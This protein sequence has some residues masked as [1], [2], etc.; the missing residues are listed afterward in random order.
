MNILRPNP[1]K[2]WI[3]YAV[4]VGALALFLTTHYLS[5]HHAAKLSDEYA[6]VINKSSKQRMLS[7][8]IALFADSLNQDNF[9][10]DVRDGLESSVVEF[11]TSHAAL[12]S[13][14]SE[15][16]PLSPALHALYFGSGDGNGLDFDVRTYI[17]SARKQ[18][19]SDT[20]NDAINTELQIA[21]RGPL[22]EKLDR[23]V[24]LYEQEAVEAISGIRETARIGFLLSI[25]VLALEA[26]L[27]FWPAHRSIVGSLSELRR[28]NTLLE[29]MVERAKV[30]MQE[31]RVTRAA[32][33]AKSDFLAHMSHEFR[34][35]L[36]AISG[37]AE[38]MT[39]IGVRNLPPEKID[40]YLNDIHASSLHLR[41]MVSDVLDI[42]RI[43]SQQ[44][45]V[46][47]EHHQVSELLD[48]ALSITRHGATQRGV[49]LQIKCD[50]LPTVLCDRRSMAKCLVNILHNAI[51]Y[52]PKGSAIWITVEKN[53]DETII[54]VE[55][56]GKGFP[57]EILDNIGQPFLRSSD[58][59]VS[60][61]E[62]AGL[63]L[64]ITK[65]LM[66][67]QNGSLEIRNLSQMGARVSLILPN[68]NAD[69]RS[70]GAETYEKQTLH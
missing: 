55:D 11:E 51:K 10:G 18:L 57:Q 35:P 3:R 6:I 46:A 65:H 68:E 42:A 19:N 70:G 1:E 40:E 31:L 48:D 67:V 21:A 16:I 69:Y 56:Q 29:E 27:I 28:T 2:L 64:L 24:Y 7:Q 49:R 36:N 20:P 45:E 15:D 66:E 9:G 8:R 17:A 50:Q 61:M 62:G 59:L 37:F 43:E 25:L 63:G 47:I 14:G 12:T 60:N 5:M 22:L 44:M 23:A 13:P 33:A 26:V 38:L 32:D 39:S 41:N 4:A 34:T 54:S 52:S 53:A 30:V 58:P